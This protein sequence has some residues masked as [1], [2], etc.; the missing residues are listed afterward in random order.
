MTQK[1][2][3]LFSVHPTRVNVF[4]YKCWECL[5]SYPTLSQGILNTIYFSHDLLSFYKIWTLSRT[6]ARDPLTQTTPP[7]QI[8]RLHSYDFRSNCIVNHDLT[9]RLHV[10]QHFETICT[11]RYYHKPTR[12]RQQERVLFSPFL[13][14]TV[15]YT[16]KIRLFS[17]RIT[18]LCHSIIL[19]TFFMSYTPILKKKLK[20]GV[21][22]YNISITGASWVYKVE[23]LHSTVTI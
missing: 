14:Y 23:T 3:L 18:R 1:I 9:L 7:I 11:N 22:W 12:F 4:K 15:S 21:T 19:Y 6:V 5:L 2:K 10:I 8:G 13:S 17:Q 20:Q 16:W